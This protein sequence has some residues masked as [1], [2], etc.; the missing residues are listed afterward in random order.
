MT[1][2][3]TSVL[4]TK[5]R[6]M[7]A[8][9]DTDQD[10]TLI[11]GDLTAIADRL[12]AAVPTLP[13]KVQR[14]RDALTVVWDQHLRNMDFDGDGRI[15]PAEYERGVREAIDAG[16]SALV[17]AL[18]DVVAAS[19][20]ICDT[21][22]DGLINLDEYTLLGQAVTGGSPQDMAVAFAKL[23]LDGNGTLDAEEIRAAVTE[24]FTSEDPNARG[25]WLYGP[26]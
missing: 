20:D 21:D 26:L 22:G 23:D 12:A 2:A 4:S 24:F 17:A 14:L 10:G 15:D 6:R 5:L 13:E 9:L 16:P 19:L 8:F 3:E 7:F 1:T 11:G 18:H 25:N